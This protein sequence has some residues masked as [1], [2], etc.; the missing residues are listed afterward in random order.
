MPT[1]MT[2]LETQQILLENL[3]QKT[4]WPHPVQ[5]IEKIET[6]ISSVLLTGDFAYKIKK[7]VDFGFVNFTTLE[8][9][10]YFCAEEL[11]LNAR[12]APQ[13]YLD[14]I[15]ITGSIDHPEI[16][17]AGEAIEYAVKMR[18]FDA[19]ALLNRLLQHG[20]VDETVIKTLANAIA[21]FHHNI[22]V[23]DATSHFGTPANIL[24]SMKQNFDQIRQHISETDLLPALKRIEDWTLAQFD[25]LEGT[26]QRRKHEGFIREC[27]GDMHLGNIALDQG[28]LI[29]FD[30]I[31][32]NEDFRWIDVVS[33]LAFISMDLCANK[34]DKLATLLIN[35]YLEI[36]GD[37]AGLRLLRFYQVYRAMV[38]AK[39]ACLGHS[40]GWLQQYQSYIR[41]AEQFMHQQRPQMLLMYGLSASGKSTIASQIAQRMG[42][43]HIRSDRERK[44]L[45]AAQHGGENKLNHGLYSR[46]IGEQTYRHLLKLAESIIESGFSVIIDATFLAQA[47]REPFLQWAKSRG[48]D[49]CIIQL[50]ASPDT[51]RQRLDQRCAEQDNISDATLEVLQHQMKTAQTPSAQEPTI[52]I[53]TE[54]AVDYDGLIQ[55][56][57]TGKPAE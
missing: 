46:E 39:V 24:A 14:T 52:V 56:I 22:T 51:L 17:G 47:Q 11:R 30:G 33:E 55:Q 9:R 10:R 37:Y 7:P 25:R 43:I 38:R 49:A 31:E 32:F 18:Q 3:Q 57:A 50:D 36:T 1:P 8:R 35:H 41:L 16:N 44:R 19:D 12:L 27:H 4:V 26:L 15:A 13:I 45:F 54:Q 34:A 40:S 23:A 48:L 5:A 20:R 42:A 6:H 28:E 2:P 29:I 53:N 21:Q